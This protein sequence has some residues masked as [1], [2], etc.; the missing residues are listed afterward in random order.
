MVHF[1]YTTDIDRKLFAVK[2]HQIGFIK[3]MRMIHSINWNSYSFHSDCT[4]LHCRTDD[5]YSESLDY[6]FVVK[7]IRAHCSNVPYHFFGGC[8]YFLYTKTEPDFNHFMDPT[9]DVDVSIDIPIID[10]IGDNEPL[11]EYHKSILKQG[12]GQTEL[13][14]PNEMMRDYLNWLLNEV[15]N[16]FE[17]EFT[18]IYD[19]LEEYTYETPSILTRNIHNKVYFS[20]IE[21]TNMLKIQIECKV[22]GMQKPDH[23]LELVIRSLKREQTM[24]TWD[25]G[26]EFVSKFKKNVIVEKNGLFIQS[27]D[28]LI[29]HNIDSITNRIDTLQKH[30]L[31]N[32]IARVQYLNDIY[33]NHKVLISDDIKKLLYF[34]WQ[35]R[36]N[37]QI[38][39]YNKHY[40]SNDFMVSMIGNFLKRLRADKVPKGSF[41]VQGSFIDSNNVVKKF[42]IMTTKELLTMYENIIVRGRSLT[43]K[44]LKIRRIKSET[45]PITLSKTRKRGKSY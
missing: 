3:L 11:E 25:R 7:P 8:V 32:H 36:A 31:Y 35:N 12:D 26:S 28:E 13:T 27:Y 5:E 18:N 6:N 44:S 15:Y 34:L 29:S 30:K 9:A 21:E 2:V 22:V 38:Y 40:N 14:E 1:R 37:M 19:D 4:L 10:S 45:K 16:L 33:P 39:N 23:L 41:I 42:K 17:I 24:D 43:R 20:I